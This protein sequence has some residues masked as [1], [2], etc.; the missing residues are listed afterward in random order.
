M[1]WGHWRALGFLRTLPLLCTSP[2]EP[3]ADLTLLAPPGRWNCSSPLLEE[4]KRDS[5]MKW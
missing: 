2:G 5:D 3:C 4:R 1:L